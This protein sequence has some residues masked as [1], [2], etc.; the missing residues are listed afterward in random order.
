MTVMGDERPPTPPPPAECKDPVLSWRRG[1]EGKA[2]RYI[3]W[4]KVF[5]WVR[6]PEAGSTP[7]HGHVIA[8]L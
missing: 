5:A 1:L 2:S 7:Q 8:A 6:D 3:R 4:K